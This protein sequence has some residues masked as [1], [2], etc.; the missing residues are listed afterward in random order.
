MG[1]LLLKLAADAL[2]VV[3]GAR[4]ELLEGEVL[5][6][7][8]GGVHVGGRR[9]VVARLDGDL[10]GATEHAR[11]AGDA[12]EVAGLGVIADGDADELAVVVPETGPGRARFE[13][14]GVEEA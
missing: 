7:P 5:L 14:L 10:D 1:D 4:E 13:P 6:A 3:L 12:R 2:A 11:D 8:D 9:A